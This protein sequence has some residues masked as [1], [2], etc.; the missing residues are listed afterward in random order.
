MNFVQWDY[1]VFKLINQ[2]ISI[3]IF[4]SLIPWLRAPLFWLPLYIFIIAFVFFNFGK[5]AYWIVIFAILTVSTA[6]LVSSRIIKTTVQRLRPCRTENLEVIQRVPCGSGFSFT[7]SHATN[8]FSIA[9]FLGLTLGQ[10]RRRIRWS[11]WIWAG[12][13]SFAQVFVGVHFPIDILAGAVMG[14]IIGKLWSLLF[15]RYY[16]HILHLPSIAHES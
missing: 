3:P 10:F 12:S 16:G 1:Y 7:S 11:L 9:T 14:F 13:I 15:F 5:K 2:G 6:D 8:H 4:E